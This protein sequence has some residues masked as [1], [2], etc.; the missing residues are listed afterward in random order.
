MRQQ[1][2]VKEHRRRA[3]ITLSVPVMV[4][5]LDTGVKCQAM[6]DTVDVSSNGALLRLRHTLPLGTRLR[7]DVLHSNQVTEA[8]VI[9]CDMDETRAWKIGMAQKA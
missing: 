6:C 4:T 7:L 9:R 1:L 3:R 2:S 5:S 8:R